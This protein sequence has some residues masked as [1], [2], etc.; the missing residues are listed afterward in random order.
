M[1]NLAAANSSM[2]LQG[3]D[4][5]MNVLDVAM[6]KEDALAKFK[7]INWATYTRPG[8]FSLDKS[9]IAAIREIETVAKAALQK[10]DEANTLIDTFLRESGCSLGQ[11][12]IKLIKNVTEPSVLRYAFARM[13]DLLPG[14]IRILIECVA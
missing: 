11:A 1:A 13:D 6:A 4:G 9:E 5:K 12:L 8:G 7:D 10:E 3:P 14:T 2:G